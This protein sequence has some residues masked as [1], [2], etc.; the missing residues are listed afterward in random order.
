MPKLKNIIPLLLIL[1][2][3]AC[4]AEPSTGPE[5]IVNQNEVLPSVQVTG[6]SEADFAQ[7]ETLSVTGEVRSKHSSTLTPTVAGTVARVLVESGDKVKQGDL[8]VDLSGNSSIQQLF[9]Q[10][11]TLKKQLEQQRRSVFLTK[12][13]LKENTQISYNTTAA[14]LQTLYGTLEDTKTINQRTSSSLQNDLLALEQI[15]AHV[16]RDT[17]LAEEGTYLGSQ[18]LEI[19]ASSTAST[20]VNSVWSLLKGSALPLAK[21]LNDDSLTDDLEDYVDDLEDYLDDLSYSTVYPDLDE[22]IN[23]LDQITEDLRKLIT[24]ASEEEFDTNL[25]SIAAQYQTAISQSLSGL[26][27]GIGGLEALVLQFDSYDNSSERQTSGVTLNLLQLQQQRDSL[28]RQ[29]ETTKLQLQLQLTQ[30]ESQI[31]STKGA[32]SSIAW[33]LSSLQDSSNPQIEGMQMQL[34]TMEQSLSD[35]QA[36]I[37]RL[38]ITAPFTGIINDVMVQEGE[39]VAPGTPLL[40][41]ATSAKELVAFV[42]SSDVTKLKQGTPTQISLL[43]ESKKYA[44]KVEKIA[45]SANTQTH[46]VE[47]IFR[48]LDQSFQAIPGTV[49]DVDFQMSSTQ[50]EQGN[51]V[52]L[53]A[54]I[55]EEGKAFVVVIEDSTAKQVPVEIGNYLGEYVEVQGELNKDAKIAISGHKFL[56]EGDKVEIQAV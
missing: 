46:E 16:Q 30:I 47:V 4:G 49:L 26:E 53:N 34:E 33:I 27:Q 8:L 3:A 32:L 15:I 56:S 22:L 6:L 35:L 43:G 39:E 21:L 50:T 44:A 9:Q 45:P 25:Q 23:E 19:S 7:T 54:V 18:Q 5:E 31:T 13:S 14:S 2:L 42:H 29:I 28:A 24:D 10:E 1:A 37:S 55:F 41:L 48:L 12:K 40:Q 20:L 52:P 51:Y 11:N 17:E 38:Q 36:T